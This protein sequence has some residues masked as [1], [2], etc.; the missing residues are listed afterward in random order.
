MKIYRASL[1]L[2]KMLKMKDLTMQ[3]QKDFEKY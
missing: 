3:S 2:T 1:G